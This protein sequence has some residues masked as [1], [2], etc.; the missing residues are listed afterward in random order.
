MK[1]GVASCITCHVCLSFYLFLAYGE[2]RRGVDKKE[3]LSF[4]IVRSYHAELTRKLAEIK[5]MRNFLFLLGVSASLTGVFERLFCIALSKGEREIV[6][7]LIAKSYNFERGFFI[8]KSIPHPSPPPWGGNDNH[9]ILSRAKYLNPYSFCLTPHPIPLH[10]ERV[11]N[12]LAS[13]P[14]ERN[15]DYVILSRA[16]YLKPTVFN[17]T[18]L[19][20]PPPWGGNN[21]YVILSRAKYLNPY[22]FCLTPHPIPLPKERVI[23]NLA[24]V[25]K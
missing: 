7:E 25:P 8:E 23:N 24:S 14:K 5:S 3:K 22:L 4:E 18:P 21:N 1:T 15:N 2:V 13:V 10:K 9:V 19:P 11:I 16:K 12:N 6:F 17:F 20:S